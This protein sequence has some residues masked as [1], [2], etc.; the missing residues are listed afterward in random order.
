MDQTF[1]R[2]TVR[3]KNRKTV[4]LG[5]RD[6]ESGGYRILCRKNP[7]TTNVSAEPVTEYRGDECPR[8]QKHAGGRWKSVG[9]Q[10]IGG[11]E[12]PGGIRFER[13]TKLRTPLLPR[14]KPN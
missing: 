8:C 2:V 11:D 6:A 10:W 13:G 9:G 4:H 14:K 12:E 7:I 3:D 1:L 5:T